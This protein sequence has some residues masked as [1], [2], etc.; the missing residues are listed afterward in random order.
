[1]IRHLTLYLLCALADV[2]EALHCGR[3]SAWA[4]RLIDVK[5]NGRKA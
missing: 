2:C 1:M 4:D 3:V 5:L